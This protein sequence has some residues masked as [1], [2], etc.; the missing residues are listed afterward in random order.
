MADKLAVI[1]EI[2]PGGSGFHVVD[3][4]NVA[5]KG[6]DLSKYLAS[7]EEEVGDKADK[8]YVDTELAKKANVSDFN[9]YKTSNN[10][11][12][13]K[14]ANTSD[15]NTELGK[16]LNTSDF[17]TYK[18]VNDAAVAGKANKSYVD[19]EL[20][21]KANT[22]D[23][24]AKANASDVAALQTAVNNKADGTTVSALAG[25]VST[26]ETNIA[27]ANSRIDE[28]VAIPPGS[29]E[30][31]TELIDIRTGADGKKYPTAGDAVRQQVTDLKSDLSALI[32][33]K[34][35]TIGDWVDNA[36]IDYKTGNNKSQNGYARTNHINIT[37]TKKVIINSSVIESDDA[38]LA[39][40][41]NTNFISGVKL[42]ATGIM[43]IN[44]PDNATSVRFSCLISK[45][46]TAY[47]AEKASVID[48]VKNDVEKNSNEIENIYA[49]LD[50]C[51]K[52]TIKLTKFDVEGYIRITGELRKDSGWSATLAI[53]TDGNAYIDFSLYQLDGTVAMIAFYD[54]SY[55]LISVITNVGTD[56]TVVTGRANVPTDAKYFRATM[57][58][59][60]EG[61]YVKYKSDTKKLSEDVEAIKKQ[62]SEKNEYVIVDNIA[63]PMNFA[64]SNIIG[65]GDSI[66]YGYRSLDTS[67]VSEHPWREIFKEKSGAS[68]FTNRSVGGAG[69]AR[70]YN[71]IL[72]QLEG[73]TLSTRDFIFVA[74][75]T[76]DY[77]YGVSES[78]F[79]TGIE[80][81]FAFID[82][83]K[84]ENTKVIIITP[85]NRSQPSA[86]DNPITLDWYRD[87][88]TK[89]A[90]EHRYS[91]I[92]GSKM[93]FPNVSSN[94]QSL[95]MSDG[96]HPTDLGYEIYANYLLGIL[97]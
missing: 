29:T 89:K 27:A 57:R 82:S 10:A 64:N 68:N 65:F 34:E 11:E 95:V 96:L 56:K 55:N 85:I 87:C 31:N 38:G 54:S 72:M 86:N 21:K 90:L 97:I 81:T 60:S 17:N 47:L 8:E 58:N 4:K 59:A 35:I 92:D 25:R 22:S 36:Y 16:K 14:K 45:R 24:A 20:A 50:D 2:V 69:Y 63:K 62:L 74:A 94:Y 12:V 61:Q 23:L 83:N 52:N 43:E 88:L 9:A 13:A 41:A 40:Y 66:M 91:V 26:N 15:V 5:Y 3:A 49:E 33:E 77:H 37:G 1:A 46:D 51:V 70:Q 19:A 78:E 80:N 79:L 71:S 93:G 53:P 30:G 73:Q 84:G 6:D 7:N 28:I 18:S 32:V 42:K 75:G 76:N 67:D 48:D 39:F 44:V